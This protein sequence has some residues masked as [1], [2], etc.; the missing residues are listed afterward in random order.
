MT[1][2]GL[3]PATKYSGFRAVLGK[4]SKNAP[5]FTTEATTDVTNGDFS[6][7]TKTIDIN[8]IN[9]GGSYK[10]VGVSHTNRSSILVY[11]PTGWAI[12]NQKTAYAGSATLNPWFVVPS[13][14]A[15]DGVVELRSV[16]YDHNG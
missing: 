8:P 13:T 3:I 9:A 12:I 16:A 4:I 14:L 1:S 7:T 6:A 10:Y 5:E 2:S 11:E 15:S